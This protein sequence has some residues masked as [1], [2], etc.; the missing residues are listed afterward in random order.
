MSENLA[1]DIFHQEQGAECVEVQ[2]SQLPLRYQ[3]GVSQ[4]INSIQTASGLLDLKAWDG[5]AIK[6]P[7]TIAFL[8][9]MMSNDIQRIEVGQL[10]SNLMSNNKGKIRYHVDILRCSE[11][12]Y[13]VLAEPG[14]GQYV[15]AYLDHF[16][17][18]EDLE[19]TP[20]TE[21]WRCD[22]LG[23]L[24][25]TSLQTLGCTKPF[26]QWEF[27]GQTITTV[28][29]PLG[30]LPRCINIVPQEKYVAF[31]QALLAQDTTTLVG[32]DAYDQVRIHEGVPRSGVD[33]TQDNFPQEASLMDHISYTK[34]CYI[35]QETHARMYH[36]GHPNW[37]S[38]A[39]VAPVDLSLTVG[40]K[41]FHQNQEVGKITS[42]SDIVQDN[43]RRGIAFVK[44]NIVQEGALLAAESGQPGQIEQAPLATAK[45]A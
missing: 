15:E 29:V 30:Q 32:F 17:I 33:Y 1:I 11:H 37:Q 24:A 25:E 44:Y 6:G 22:L 40:Q 5:L 31:F 38:V 20:F 7:D 27:E 36:R 41:L 35:G 23:P 13:M 2:S 8:Q 3:T 18:Q 45:G 16:H 42:L 39:M 26:S 34:G 43:K 19:I 4:E 9:G 12:D 14:E 28:S 21:H 10:Q